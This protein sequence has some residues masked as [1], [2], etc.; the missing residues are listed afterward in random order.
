MYTNNVKRNKKLS[1]GTIIPLMLAFIMLISIQNVYAESDILGIETNVDETIDISV[2]ETNTE[3]PPVDTEID[4]NK[5]TI[6]DANNDILSPE[7]KIAQDLEAKRQQ[8]IEEQKRLEAIEMM[9]ARSSRDV[10]YYEINV[11]TDLS[12]MTTIDA[13]QMNEIINYWGSRRGG[14]MPF[15]GQGQ[16]F[17]DAAKQSGLDPVYI[18]AHAAVE[19]GWGTSNY[20]MYHYNYFGIGAF[21][22]NPDNAANY[23]NAGMANGIIEGAKWIANN[24]YSV[25][26]TSLYGMRYSNSGSHDYCSSTTWAYNIADIMATSYSIIQS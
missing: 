19:S 16:I 5:N 10:Q 8:E 14:N 12:I 13:D 23:A 22:S 9:T 3:P 2:E 24:F 1:L 20:A 25:G 17:I 21:D 11:Y 18:L 7:R 4:S 6:A 26:Q 15:Y